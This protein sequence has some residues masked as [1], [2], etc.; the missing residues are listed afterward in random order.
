MMPKYMKPGARSVA[1]SGLD[2]SVFGGPQDKVGELTPPGL[3]SYPQGAGEVSYSN[4][5][6]TPA[7][8]AYDTNRQGMTALINP[9][10]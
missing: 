10:D 8:A 3:V 6:S 7:T 2:P 1:G 9:K 4:G 5:A